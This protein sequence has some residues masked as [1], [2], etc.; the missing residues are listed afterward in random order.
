MSM[1][2][3]RL[4]PLSMMIALAFGRDDETEAG[5]LRSGSALHE[6]SSVHRKD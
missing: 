2:E 4:E 6:A 5:L 3:P 1:H